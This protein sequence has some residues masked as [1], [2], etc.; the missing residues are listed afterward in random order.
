MDILRAAMSFGASCVVLAVVV[1][2]LIIYWLLGRGN[3]LRQRSK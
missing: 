2:V 3:P 1:I